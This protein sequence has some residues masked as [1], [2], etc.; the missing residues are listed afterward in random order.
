MFTT[1]TLAKHQRVAPPP[2]H[3]RLTPRTV[4][5]LK[6]A[7]DAP[8]MP[9]VQVIEK[10]MVECAHGWK[11]DTRPT[12][13]SAPIPPLGRESVE[14]RVKYAKYLERQEKEVERMHAHADRH[15]PP[16]FDFAAL[17]CLSNEEVEKLSASRPATLRE[18]SDIPGITPKAVLYLYTHLT[19]KRRPGR[20]GGEQGAAAADHPLRA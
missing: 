16:T 20:G 14:I 8:L 7:I 17:P 12:D 11:Q 15:I 5:S 9:T 1:P 2:A 13:G 19:K 10:A 6:R 3:T 18:A 4:A